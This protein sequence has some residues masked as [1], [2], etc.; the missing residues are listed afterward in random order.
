M[1]VQ[2]KYSDDQLYFFIEKGFK[3]Y[4][5]YIYERFSPI[6]YGFL[7]NS[8]LSEKYA[9]DILE[10][11][12]LKLFG[13]AASKPVTK[14]TFLLWMIQLATESTRNYLKMNNIVYTFNIKNN[15]FLSIEF[16]GTVENRPKLQNQ[17]IA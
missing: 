3:E 10:D 13:N 9:C 12:F 1:N 11:V 7:L 8:G 6:I 15:S 5:E 14:I 17:S 2:S 4:Y 16:N